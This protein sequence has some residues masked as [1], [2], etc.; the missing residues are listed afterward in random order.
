MEVAALETLCV[1][2]SVLAP[3]L[4]CVVGVVDAVTSTLRTTK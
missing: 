2:S 1:T 4:I 3:Q